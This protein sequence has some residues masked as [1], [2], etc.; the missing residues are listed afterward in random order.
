PA[1]WQP[2]EDLIVT[3]AVSDADARERFGDFTAVLPYLRKVSM[4][5]T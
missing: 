1:Q 5:T 3:P 2:G 4:P